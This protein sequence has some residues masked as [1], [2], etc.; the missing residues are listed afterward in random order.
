MRSE[1]QPIQNDAPYKVRAGY[2]SLSH[3]ALTRCAE[4]VCASAC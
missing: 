3:L 2:R 4:D 1:T